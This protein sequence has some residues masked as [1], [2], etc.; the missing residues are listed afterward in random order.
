MANFKYELMSLLINARI[1]EGNA[2]K[3]LNQALHSGNYTKKGELR[4]Y[5]ASKQEYKDG[6]G[7]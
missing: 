3:K 1:F 7:S 6:E 4:F 2:L 5:V